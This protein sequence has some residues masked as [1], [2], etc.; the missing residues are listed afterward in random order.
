MNKNQ[1]VEG[2]VEKTFFGYRR[3]YIDESSRIEYGWHLADSG[4]SY[5]LQRFNGWRW[6]TVAWTYGH[7]MQPYTLERVKEYLFWYES[8]EKKEKVRSQPLF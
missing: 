7:T 3:Y 2:A 8:E 5:Q 4:K 1:I 6:R